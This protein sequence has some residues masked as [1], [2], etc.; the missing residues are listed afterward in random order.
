MYLDKLVSEAEIPEKRDIFI[1]V[2]KHA[3]S[4]AASRTWS[5]LIITGEYRIALAGL[6]DCFLNLTLM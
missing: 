4:Q 2:T 6:N 5:A 1:K 3:L